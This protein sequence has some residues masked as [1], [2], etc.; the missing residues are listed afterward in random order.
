MEE[1]TLGYILLALLC[2]MF[3]FVPLA[4]CA[5]LA[6]LINAFGGCG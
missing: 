2:S 4:G 1:S 6:Q 3:G 5:L